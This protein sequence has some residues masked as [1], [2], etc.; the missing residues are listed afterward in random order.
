MSL[1]S[2]ASL[3]GAILCARLVSSAAVT[4][5]K[6]PVVNTLNGSYVGLYNSVYN[7]DIFLGV[8]YAQPPVG[9][10]RFAT[11]RS[12]NTTWSGLQNATEYGYSCVGYGEDTEISAKN[13]T[14]EDCLFLN[15]ARP[16]GIASTPLPV[17]I[18]IHGGG[19]AYGSGSQGYYN[20]SFLVERSIQIQQPIIAI[21]IN[22]RLAGWGWLYSDEIV[23][24]GSTNAGL[25]DQR[26]ALHWIKENIAAFGGDP[27]KITIFGESAGSYSVSAH[28]FA[29]NGRDDELFHAA[30]GQSASVAGIGPW[31]PSIERAS[32][33]TANITKTICPEATDKLACLRKADFETLNNAINAT[34]SLPF[35]AIVYGPVVDGDIVARPRLEQL[36]DG[37]FVKVPLLLGT[38]NDEAGYYT[39]LGINTENELHEVLVTQTVGLN[40][41]QA[42][43]IMSQY[44]YSD[45]DLVSPEVLNA[46][47]NTTV[48]ILYKRANTILTDVVFKAPTHYGAQLWQKH[49][50]NIYVYNA[51]TTISVGPNYFGSAH[52]FELAYMFYNVNGTGWEGGQPPFLGGNPF[53]GRPQSYLDLAA[54]MSGLWVGF[55][56]TG[57]PSYSNRES[58][59]FRITHFAS[60][61]A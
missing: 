48:G 61:L 42:T 56:N 10:L 2:I 29:Y 8:P 37:S 60:S 1:K 39:P 28:V 26:L 50:S 11:P 3:L 15:I 49:S 46:E 21:T 58:F 20:V 14:S 33:A 53:A 22:Y 43:E 38:N 5:N 9:D 47:L 40:F 18:F 23:K 24:E 17:A 45:P 44:K 6:A 25:R 35:A 12:L 27:S 7:Q 13:R 34:L 59:P 30:I 52:G 36:R 55:M 4:S 57:I 41:T 54:V 19:W 51:N 16:A 32:L 31:E